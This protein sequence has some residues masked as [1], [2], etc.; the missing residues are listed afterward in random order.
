MN[1]VN[2]CENEPLRH[3]HL[4]Y[5]SEPKHYNYFS[6]MK[7]GKHTLGKLQEP[8]LIWL[9]MQWEHVVFT[10]VGILKSCSGAADGPVPLSEVLQH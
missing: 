6:V 7:L 8:D 3:L 10:V 5:V 1:S 4:H 9:F 2:H